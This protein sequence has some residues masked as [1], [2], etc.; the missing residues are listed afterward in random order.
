VQ[1]TDTI[2]V[3][4][5]SVVEAVRTLHDVGRRTPVL[6]SCQLDRL[7]GAWIILKC[8]NFPRGGAVLTEGNVA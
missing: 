5:A 3:T 2:D 6:T 4:F 8:E 1:T 7:S